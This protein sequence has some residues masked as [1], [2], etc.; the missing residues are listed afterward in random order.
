MPIDHLLPGSLQ[1]RE[2][3]LTTEVE[4]ELIHAQPSLVA[5]VEE[6]ALLE[7][8]KNVEVLGFHFFIQVSRR[9]SRK[10]AQ[11]SATR[12]AASPQAAHAALAERPDL[13]AI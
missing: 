10:P 1:R 5:A 6:Q 4:H 12:P 7:G 2:A 8:R 3:Q 9:H 11:H 13:R